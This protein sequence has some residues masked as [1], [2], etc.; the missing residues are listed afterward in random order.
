MRM[1]IFAKAKKN[2]ISVIKKKF[3]N[4]ITEQTKL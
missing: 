4:F 3:Q 2:L 1:K